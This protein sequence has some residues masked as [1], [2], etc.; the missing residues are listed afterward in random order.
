MLFIQEDLNMDRYQFYKI[1]GLKFDIIVTV[2]DITI[3]ISN[4]I[5]VLLAVT[6]LITVCFPMHALRSTVCR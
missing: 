1:Y 2:G 4:S 6:R 3:F 5:T